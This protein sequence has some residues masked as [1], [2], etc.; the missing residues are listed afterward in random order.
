[1]FNCRLCGSEDLHPL[2]EF[3]NIPL[4]NAY[5]SDECPE[6]ESH[7]LTFGMCDMC[8]L[9]QIQEVLPHDIL[10]GKSY[11]WVSG[12]S[13]TNQE[14]C[15]EF[16]QNCKKF[17]KRLDSVVLEIGCNDGTLL[18]NFGVA[19][20][21]TVGVDPSA[22]GENNDNIINEPWTASRARLMFDGEYR[23]PDLIVAR[24]VIGHVSNPVDFV[25]GIATALA[26]DGTA[27]IETPYAGFLRDQLQ[28]DTVFHEHVCYFTI[29]TLQ[30]LFDVVDMQITK[31][32][33]S[34]MNG[35]S[36][37]C[38]VKHGHAESIDDEVT[39]PLTEMETAN[40]LHR[41][42]MW[43]GFRDTVKHSIKVFRAT[44][45]R[46]ADEDID[47]AAY[48]SAAK[49]NTLLHMANINNK[50]IRYMVDDNELKQ[51]KRLARADIPVVGLSQAMADKPD[52]MVVG[53]WNYADEI[54]CRLR[55]HGY[56]GEI[57]LPLPFP[58][59]Y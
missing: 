30:R 31:V 8:E 24:N 26:A 7:N 18:K 37:V 9:L 42:T 48:G 41:P 25:V 40:G 38:E 32:D 4:A 49:F 54:Y 17:R 1:M 2:L 53:A 28:Y 20:W 15:R 47:V 55:S 33:W 6:Y 43:T 5:V 50:Q 34:P 21:K 58:K 46:Y 35:G 39:R 27:V 19:G 51:N 22:A 10:F 12:T 13:R 36:F 16:A 11:P 52:V 57:L 45:E 56:K 29:T 59:V 23:N 14:Y 44:L 3:P